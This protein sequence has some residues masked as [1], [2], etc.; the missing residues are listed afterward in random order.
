MGRWLQRRGEMLYGDG[1]GLTPEGIDFS[2]NNFAVSCNKVNHDLM[3]VSYLEEQG[4][5]SADRATDAIRRLN[6]FLAII[7]P[8][9]GCDE[10]VK[11]PVHCLTISAIQRLIQCVDA[12]MVNRV[13]VPKFS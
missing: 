4:L 11:L 5:L 3:Q 13:G 7:E 12:A 10:K 8:M 1:I 9:I 6:E 2:D